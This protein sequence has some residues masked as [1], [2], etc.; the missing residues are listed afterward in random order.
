LNDYVLSDLHR[1]YDTL[2]AWLYEEYTVAEGYK[3]LVRLSGTVGLEKYDKTVSSMLTA[4]KNQ[5]DAKDK[6]AHVSDKFFH[7]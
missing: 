2:L 1:H 7:S 4:M 3:G 5:L 6:Y